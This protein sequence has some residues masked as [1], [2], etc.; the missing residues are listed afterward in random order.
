MTASIVRG[1]QR[2]GGSSESEQLERARRCGWAQHGAEGCSAA[3]A[4]LKRQRARSAATLARCR[5]RARRYFPAPRG[6][7]VFR[8]RTLTSSTGVA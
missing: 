6:Y 4:H 3:A 1:Q 2:P 7:L 5:V 8:G